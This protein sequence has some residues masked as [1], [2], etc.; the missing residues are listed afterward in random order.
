MGSNSGKNKGDRDV[1]CTMMFMLNHEP[2][3][4]KLEPRLARLLGVHTATRST[5]IHSLWQYIKKN[6]LQVWLKI[7]E[8]ITLCDC[9]IRLI[10]SGS[11]WINTC[12]KYSAR[13]ASA[14]PIFRGGCI[15][16]WA[17]QIQLPFT[18]V[19]VAIRM[20]RH[21]T[22]QHAMTS[23]SRLTTHWSRCKPSFCWIR[24]IRFLYLLKIFVR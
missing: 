8:F 14:L 6:K 23:R 17:R 20:N 9:R 1:K 21:G 13:I 10:G 22:R 2:S 18:I 7:L 3:Q 15:P 5:I 16:C 11:I 4:F 12:V 19:S 24:L